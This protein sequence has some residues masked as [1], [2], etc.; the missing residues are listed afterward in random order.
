MAHFIERANEVVLEHGGICT[1]LPFDYVE[2]MT[3]EDFVRL[4][5]S[6]LKRE[7][8]ER[9]LHVICNPSGNE[10]SL[11]LGDHATVYKLTDCQE[12]GL[13]DLLEEYKLPDNP[14][15]LMTPNLPWPLVCESTR[16]NGTTVTVRLPSIKRLYRNET[17]VAFNLEY[18]CPEMW[19]SVDLTPAGVFAGARV[20]VVKDFKPD[21]ND[22]VLYKWPLAN[23]HHDG[24]ICYG[25]GNLSSIGKLGTTYEKIAEAVSMFLDATFNSDLVNVSDSEASLNGVAA[26]PISKLG[27][28][29][30]TLLAGCTASRGGEIKS[31]I[32]LLWAMKEPGG[33]RQLRLRTLDIPPKQFCKA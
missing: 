28:P 32:K 8:T 22:T 29:Y 2:R 17:C 21:F 31:V 15:K 13:S 5:L 23:V 16:G 4:R 27:E 20:A 30:D 9:S 1:R 14:V 25:G 12:V 24:K 6:K 10:F 18:W 19:F 7:D 11:L 3:V 26:W 33:W